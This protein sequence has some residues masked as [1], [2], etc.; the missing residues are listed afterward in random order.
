MF[1]YV[2]LMMLKHSC[3]TGD[4]EIYNLYKNLVPYDNFELTKVAL[5]YNQNDFFLYIIENGRRFR[6]Y[7]VI[8]FCDIEF[9]N[10]LIVRKYIEIYSL[11]FYTYNLNKHE[12][13]K[14]ILENHMDE[15]FYIAQVSKNYELAKF[16]TSVYNK[17]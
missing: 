12:L 13:L 10:E 7:D 3:K 2:N 11:Y 15:L 16:L 6:M 17:I 1:Y 5:E 9:I 4:R 14:F 8:L